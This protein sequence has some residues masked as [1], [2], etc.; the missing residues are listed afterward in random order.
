M[1]WGGY[2]GFREDRSSITMSKDAG[3]FFVTASPL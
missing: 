1:P 3:E 2:Y